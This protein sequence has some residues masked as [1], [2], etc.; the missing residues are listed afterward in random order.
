[1][2]RDVFVS[3]KE[4]SSGSQSLEIICEYP[5]DNWRAALVEREKDLDLTGYKKISVDIYI[6]KKAPKGM[7]LGRIIMTVGDGWHFTQM[8][9]G[10][11]LPRGKWTTLEVDLD[12]EGYTFMTSPWRGRK[13]KRLYKHLGKVK[14]IAVRV[15]YDAAPPYRI[16]P[17]YHGPIYMDNIVIK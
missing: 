14:K 8:K 13:E 16:G 12:N 10:V 5:G 6:P 1:M 3:S 9:E 7:F 4:A 17:K 11:P 2:A 15:E